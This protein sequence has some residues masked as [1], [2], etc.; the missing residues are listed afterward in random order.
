LL[1]LRTTSAAETEAL[2][3]ALAAVLRPGDVVLVCGDLGAGK[4]T[5]VRGACRALG[6]TEP[7]TSPTFTVGHLYAG[8]MPVAH[9]DLYRFVGLSAAEWGDLEPYFDGTIAFVEWPEAGRGAL[10]SPRLTLTLRHVGPDERV[11]EADSPDAAL[12]EELTRA[13]PGVRHGD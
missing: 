12:L 3:G 1:V 10:P 4:T 9:L 7:V 2:G 5:L 13:H 11:V 6:I 8:R